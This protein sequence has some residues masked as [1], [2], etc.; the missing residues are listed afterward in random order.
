MRYNKSVYSK[1]Q[2]KRWD[3]AE[4][5]KQKMYAEHSSEVI[6][7]FEVAGYTIRCIQRK[8][9]ACMDKENEYGIQVWTEDPNTVKIENVA[10]ACVSNDWFNNCNEAN[11]RF[12]EVKAM[13]Y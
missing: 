5:Y 9:D 7:D 6:K 11:A 10:D 2:Y 4:Q 8:Y 1:E 13:C 3:A 12:K